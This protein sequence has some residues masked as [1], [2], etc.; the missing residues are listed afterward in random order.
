MSKK[1]LVQNELSLGLSLCACISWQMHCSCVIYKL[2]VIGIVCALLYLFR[3]VAVVS[4][5][6]A[7]SRMTTA[8]ERQK[9][10]QNQNGKAQVNSCSVSFCH[11]RLLAHT[12]NK[13][14]RQ[15]IRRRRKSKMNAMKCI[16]LSGQKQEEN[17]HS[18]MFFFPFL[19]CEFL[20]QKR[21][22]FSPKTQTMEYTHRTLSIVRR[23]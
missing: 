13:Q 11:C 22:S 9:Q 15:E 12:H 5:P 23:S 4:V 19:K 7:Y 2:T 18:D 1:K 10:Q 16:V 8:K 3:L 14:P 17:N 21:F 6:K 20:W